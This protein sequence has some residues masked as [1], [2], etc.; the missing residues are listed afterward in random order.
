MIQYSTGSTHEFPSS[1]SRQLKAVKKA[2]E[3]CQAQF[4]KAT[5]DRRL[6]LKSRRTGFTVAVANVIY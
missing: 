4:L 5:T 2:V 6:S 3:S 1:Y